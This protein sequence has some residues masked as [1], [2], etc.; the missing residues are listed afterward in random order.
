[1]YMLYTFH[2]LCI[3]VVLTFHYILKRDIREMKRQE[4]AKAAQSQSSQSSQ[5]SSEEEEETVQDIIN[6][7]MKKLADDY[8]SCHTTVR[9]KLLLD[10]DDFK[11][12]TSQITSPCSDVS[13]TNDFDNPI[14]MIIKLGSSV[15]N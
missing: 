1:M 10:P 2:I 8:S 7:S 15:H 14:M 13:W 6:G 4:Q 12:R 5:S 9:M 3:L 11:N